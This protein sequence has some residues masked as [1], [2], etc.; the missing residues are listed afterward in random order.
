MRTMRV[1]KSLEFDAAHRLL[2]YKGK[3]ATLH[4]HRYRVV[5][6]LESS[7][8]DEL[9]MVLDFTEVKNT[10]GRWI[11]EHWDHATLLSSEDPLCAA[12]Q[13]D[14]KQFGS[15]VKEPFLFPGNPTAE[16]MAGYLLTKTRSLLSEF[17]VRVRSVRVYETPTSYAEVSD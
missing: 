10:I 8:L 2:N 17:N 12:L 14:A 6:E 4:G 1:A 16:V 13:E 9:G 3:C 7:G 11:D 5:V 15:S